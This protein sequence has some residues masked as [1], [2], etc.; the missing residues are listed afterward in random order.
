MQLDP[1]LLTPEE[2]LRK[3]RE[4]SRNPDSVVR[5]PHSELENAQHG[6]GYA[7]RQVVPAD[8]GDI[9]GYV[10]LGA[11]GYQASGILTGGKTIESVITDYLAKTAHD[12]R[13]LPAAE[14]GLPQR[15]AL[16]AV[17]ADGAL[18]PAT[19][20]YARYLLIFLQ[21]SGKS[22][23][24]R[25]DALLRPPEP[26][27]Q[28]THA[29]PICGRPA[30]HQERYPRSVCDAC[31]DRTVDRT[32]L[33]VA[34]SNIDMSG[35]FVAYYVDHSRVRCEEVTRTGQCWIDGHEAVMGEARFGGI[36]VQAV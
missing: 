8:R 7:F 32:G 22:V 31:R 11:T 14:L 5:F 1:Q 17:E 6:R 10:L 4:I 34:G 20:D 2:A 24:A 3:A 33:R 35:G 16:A 15:L 19:V 12:H 26:G 30:I 28:Y 21:R 23:L 36:V 27:R 29:C 25:E 18:D 13:E 9:D